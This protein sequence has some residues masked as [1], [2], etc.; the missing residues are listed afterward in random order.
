LIPP[1]R[2][3]VTDFIWPP[4]I[5]L[6]VLPFDGPK[7]LSVIAGG[8]LQELAERVQQLPSERRWPL[9]KLSR[10]V[11][12]IPPSRIASAH[13]ETPQKARDVLNATHALRVGLQP[14]G[15]TLSAH[16]AVINLSSQLPV[17]ELSLQYPQKDAGA[18]SAALTHFVALAFNLRE[19]SSEDK[20]SAAATAPYLKGVY[21]LNSDWHRFDDAMA[22]FQEAARLDPNSALPP[23]GMALALVQKFNHVKENIYLEQAQAFVHTAQS[24]NPDSVRVL[25][26]SGR[27]NE[28]NS[29]YLRALE[30]YRRVQQLEPRNV[31]ALLGMA[32]AYER[33]REPEEA[34]ATYRKA[35]VLDPDYYRPY[36][37]LGAFYQRHGRYSE[38]VDQFRK[39]IER[40]PGLP[41]SY[42]GM[43][44][45]LMQLG[46]YD[47]AEE[48][49]QKS[50]QIRETAQGLNNM[51]AL[52]C[53][54]KRFD[55]A[56]AY[57]KRALIYDPN[58][59][60]WLLNVADNLRWAGHAAEARPYYVKGRDRA[61]AEMTIDPQSVRA[62]AYFG[63]LSAR[64]DERER[65]MEEIKQAISL[66]P[67]DSEVL[68]YALMT[69]ESL[70]ERNLAIELLHRFTLADANNMTS[71]PDL[72][73]FYRDPRVK[74]VM[75]D[76]GGQ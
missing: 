38:A 58:N 39:M 45:P 46:R 50:L 62:R 1:L 2:Q 25:L 32:N 16:A 42:S 73:D 59:Y 28:A 72:A 63:Y 67:T 76:K 48:A 24:R 8:A 56:A 54:Q 20:L 43:S 35:Q 41:D 52:R 57:Q 60:F 64:L 34:V 26:A 3:W 30:D 10:S 22:Q 13:A 11:V 75:I 55:E 66:A 7:E 23:A 69:Y 44:A 40:A 19:S 27:V 4:N 37:M 6:A 9:N 65:A 53:R 14:E 18:M 31:E 12:V 70:G 5:R 68:D 21:F 74:Q 36:H 49:L 47:E 15:D 17:K 71:V 33:L 61:R 29:Q 51:G